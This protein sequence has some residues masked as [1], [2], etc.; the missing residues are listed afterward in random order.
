MVRNVC[1]ASYQRATE[2]VILVDG[3]AL[4]DGMQAAL[5]MLRRCP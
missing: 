2:V 3:K 4:P 5:G 1:L